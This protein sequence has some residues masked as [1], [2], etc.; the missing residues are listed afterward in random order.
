MGWRPYA[1]VMGRLT[2]AFLPLYWLYVQIHLALLAY[3]TLLPLG[4]VQGF[5][6]VWNAATAYAST[7]V[8]A[9]LRVPYELAGNE[10]VVPVDSLPQK[11]IVGW[12][13]N[14]F[15]PYFSFLAMILALPR[16]R[17]M[18]RGFG[19]AGGLLLINL[20]NV[21]R[22]ATLASVGNWYGKG[23]LDTYHAWMFNY[24]MSLWVVLLFYLWLLCIGGGKTLKRSL[25]V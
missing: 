12:E 20:G 2:L 22:I 5:F 18:E 16:V 25:G 21:F 11:I 8:L 23:A 15:L 9:L 1:L 4:W 7:L 19:M 17:W 6:E 3:P 10:M 14:F 13:C 24:G